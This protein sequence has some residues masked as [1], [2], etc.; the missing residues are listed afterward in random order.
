MALAGRE[1][2]PAAS[3]WTAARQDGRP[4]A[5][6]S[7]AGSAAPRSH[8]GLWAIAPLYRGLWPTAPNR[9]REEDGEAPEEGRGGA[10]GG[11]EEP[12]EEEGAGGGALPRKGGI[13]QPRGRPR[14]KS[15]DGKGGAT[16]AFGMILSHAEGRV[17]REAGARREV[18]HRYPGAV[19]H[20][21]GQPGQREPAE[22]AVAGRRPA[23]IARPLAG[24]HEERH[25]ARSRYIVHDVR[26][27]HTGR[28]QRDSD[29]G[30]RHPQR[31]LDERLALGQAARRRFV[32]AVAVPRVGASAE[33]HLLLPEQHQVHVDDQLEMTAAPGRV[34]G[35]RLHE[36]SGHG[37]MSCPARHRVSPV[38]GTVPR[39]P[40]DRYRTP[41]LL[42]IAM[43]TSRRWLWM[44]AKL[45]Q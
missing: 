16:R 1:S 26:Q 15:R 28:V 31:G 3:R 23:D 36:G 24:G 22:V 21:R 9:A 32:G 17:R 40:R 19:D 33:Q 11:R 18:P 7:H 12:E 30:R 5:P 27:R 35:Q 4:A 13:R 6:G 8:V 43:C 25:P 39:N 20:V 37:W 2:G 38:P 34:S 45:R 14:G 10:G 41:S 29:L 42:W 44:S